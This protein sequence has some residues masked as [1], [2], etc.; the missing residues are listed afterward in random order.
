[1]PKE[2]CKE[3]KDNNENGHKNITVDDS[4]SDEEDVDEILDTNLCMDAITAA[5][6]IAH[7]LMV[8]GARAVQQFG[9]ETYLVG[10]GCKNSCAD[11]NKEVDVLRGFIF[12]STF[13]ECMLCNRRRCF[14]CT[15]IAAE[16]GSNKGCLRCS[17]TTAD[18]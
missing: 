13:G 1:M 10:K 12:S 3:S 8:H 17:T 18:R 15:R 11:C 5:T 16:R 7:S 4:E 2:K 9:I 14:E 6:G